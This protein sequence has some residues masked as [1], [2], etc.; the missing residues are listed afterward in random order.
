MHHFVF[1]INFQI[2]FVS[3]TSLV[4]IH[5]L[6][7]LS[8]HLSHHAV[9]IPALI[10]HPSFTLSLQA[11][12]LPFQQIL[13]ILIDSFYILDAFVITGLDRTYHAPQFIFSYTF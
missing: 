2:H 11:L 13:P 7:H 6:I 10:I 9:I 5:L 8:T 12:N 1:G 4:S 3:L